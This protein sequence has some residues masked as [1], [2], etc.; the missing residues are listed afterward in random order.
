MKALQGMSPQVEVT[1]NRRSEKALVD[2]GCTSTIVTKDMVDTC[3]GTSSITA[4]DGREVKCNGTSIVRLM[5]RGMSLTIQAIVINKIVTGVDVVLGMDAIARLGGVTVYRNSVRFGGHQGAAGVQFEKGVTGT[6]GLDKSCTIEDQDFSAHFDGE[7]WTVK[8]AW[9]G[10]PPI[11]N[12]RVECY[13][14]TLRGGTRVEFEKEVDRWISEGILRPWTEKVEGVLPLMAVVQPTKQKVRPVLD[15]RELNVHVACHTG[16]DVMD[17]CGETMREWRQIQKAATIVDLKSAYLQ[18]HISQEFW[19]YQLVRYKGRTY[20]LTRLGFGLNSAPKIMAAILKTVLSKEDAVRRATSSYIDDILVDETVTTAEDVVKHLNSFGLIAK[21][22]ESLEGGA[23]LGLQLRKDQIGRL[24]FRRGNEIPEVSEKLSRRELFSICGRL[25]GHYPIAGWLRTACSYIKRLAS[26]AKW[27]DGV[28]KETVDIM[29]EI[30]EEVKRED[31]VRGVWHVPNSAEGVVWCDA[32]CIAVGVTLEI[33]GVT[34]EDAAW[35]RKKDDVAHINVAELDAVMKGINLAL[36]WGLQ[37]VEV[38]TDSATVF[39]WIQSEATGERRVKTKG[40]AEMLVKRRLMML[41]E[42]IREFDLQLRVTIVPSAKNRADVMT[43][44]RKTWL[45]APNEAA[46]A[47][48]CLNEDTLKDLHDMHHFGVD[49][50][51]FLARK[52]DPRITKEAVRTVVERCS[53]C[54]SID[55]APSRHEA[56]EVQ[57][58]ENWSRLAIDVTHYRQRPYLSM[59][60]CGPG[61]VA[62][63]REIKAENAGE[64]A[65]VLEEVFLERGPVTEVLMDNGTAFRSAAMENVLDKWGVRRYFRAAYRPGGN[66]IVE[67]H[68]RTIKAIAERGQI[69]PPEAVFWYNMA[70]KSGQK[71]ESVPQ[72]AVFKYEWRHPRTAQVPAEEGEKRATVRVGEE[73]WIKPPDARCTT[74][75]GR[76]IVTSVQSPN[77]VSIDG[78]PRHILDVRPVVVS[79]EEDS[80]VEP[81]S[82]VHE[83]APRRSQRERRPPCWSS[84]YVMG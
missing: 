34:A 30:I 29:R 41:R 42:L 72:R 77:N 58:A 7:K 60:D 27:E 56:G 57:V 63:W 69:S 9:K 15:F 44:V 21:R 48:C 17:V 84:D 28:D 66:G 13:E 78:I 81:S 14:H 83:E 80:D 54:Q 52:V 49:R 45:K 2:T 10:E 67:R 31:P 59:V 46:V 50:T 37:N 38:R 75:W 20:C 36:K 79:S 82:D 1:L 33:G 8:W 32:S 51:L 47:I 65:K 16:G 74:R 61:R 55:P 64:I 22:P 68:H 23:V 12:N 62:I 39:S 76:G 19:K 4:V 18:I 25:V 40:A 6:A 53:R 73:V 24:V 71:V 5:V 26:G 43:R 70:P 11:L 35:L 3:N